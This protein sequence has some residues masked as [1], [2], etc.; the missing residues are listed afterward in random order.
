MNQNSLFP[1]KQ[2]SPVKSIVEHVMGQNLECDNIVINLAYNTHRTVDIISS[3]SE[4]CAHLKTDKSICQTCGTFIGHLGYEP[5]PLMFYKHVNLLANSV[6]AE[7][8]FIISPR[9]Y[10]EDYQL[11]LYGMRV[12]AHVGYKH[13]RT[14]TIYNRVSADPKTRV[15][16][17]AFYVIQFTRK[18]DNLWPSRCLISKRL[19]LTDFLNG[20]PTLV[21]NPTPTDLQTNNSDFTFYLS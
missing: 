4:V 8:V 7:N 1:K 2:P 5:D 10:P 20:K 18:R 19:K 13:V 21:I 14:Y 17:T 9:P 15:S 16:V 6:S 3:G 12:P 11:P